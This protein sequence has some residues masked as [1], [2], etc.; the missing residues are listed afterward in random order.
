MTFHNIIKNFLA[1]QDITDLSRNAYRN[2]LKPFQR[3][4]IDNNANIHDIKRYQII[5]YKQHITTLYSDKTVNCYLTAIRMLFNWMEQTEILKD[6]PTI[7]VKLIRLNKP[8]RKKALT[9]GQIV[10]LLS[11][12]TNTETGIRVKAI[13]TLMVNTG[14][15]AIEV[16]RIHKSDITPASIQVQGKGRHTKDA[17]IGLNCNELYNDIVNQSINTKSDYLFHTIKGQQLRPK[18]ISELVNT[19]MMIAGIKSKDVSCHSL[20]HTYAV[21]VMKETNDIMRVMEYMRHSNPKT[22]Q[23]YISAVKAN[24]PDNDTMV[25]KIHKNITEAMKQYKT[26]QIPPANNTG[27][28]NSI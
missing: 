6:N 9:T 7:G 12:C 18:Y 10:K 26:N 15:R 19:Q 14:M 2:W 27:A 11:S 28:G 13:I 8:Y 17:E 3:W 20:R 24:N 1:D 16:S 23:I 4:V 22:T 25:S 21:N 5:K